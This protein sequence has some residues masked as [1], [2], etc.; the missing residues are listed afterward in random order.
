MR[1]K[2]PGGMRSLIRLRW[3]LARELV[4]VGW[5]MFTLL[6]VVAIVLPPVMSGV[7]TVGTGV[8]VGSVTQVADEGFGSPAGRRL[9]VAIVIIGVIYTVQVCITP[10]LATLTDLLGRRMEGALRARVMQAVLVPPGVAHLE[11]PDLLDRVELA[12]SIGLG[13]VRPRAAIVAATKK[14]SGQ[15]RGL[16]A[17]AL[18]F[19]FA[20]WAPLVVAAAVL[21]IR[22]AFARKMRGSVELTALNAN[23]LRRSGYYRDLALTAP[24]AKETRIFGLHQWVV[25]RF[26]GEWKDAMDVVWRHRARGNTLVWVSIFTMAG[27]YLGVFLMIGRAAAAGEI[28]LTATTVYLMATF[29]IGGIA[30]SGNDAKLDKATWPMLATNELEREVYLPDNQMGGDRPATE[31]PRSGIRFEGVRFTYPGRS[32][33]VFTGLDLEIPSGRSL[34]IVGENG[35]GKTT[36]VKL[37]A[38]L[39]DPSGGRIT[40]DGVDLRELEPQSW[41]RRVAAIFQDYVRYQLPVTDN[42][43]FGAVHRAGDTAALRESARMAG[44]TE[45]IDELPHGWDT[46]LSREFENGVDLSGGQWQ[47]IALARALFALSAGAGILVL[48]EPTAH[49]D[50]RAEAD[51]FNSFLDLTAGKTAIVISHHFSTVRRADRIV[52]IDDGQVIEEGSHDELMAAGGKYAT[53]FALQAARFSSEP[54]MAGS[55][56]A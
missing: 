10:L 51:F 25:D 12:Q 5:G 31:L 54:Q 38:R 13:E 23:S 43:G 24:A 49:L 30:D 20:W 2:G 3:T 42:I 21:F 41:A 14:Y 22:R 9:T 35:A 32:T 55:R 39:Y 28:S 4:K 17:C 19:P 6:I 40:V 1:D 52:V 11:R 26:V 15:L 34:A 46:I 44:A 33:E 50:A 48:D 53:M 29:G 18:L 7:M 36:L 8:V 56:D 27:V 47:K 16:V 37:L 45:V